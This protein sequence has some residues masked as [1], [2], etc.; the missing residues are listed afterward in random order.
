[1]SKE[2]NYLTL[3]RK[4]MVDGLIFATIGANTEHLRMLR[5]Q[6]MPVV[7]IARAPEGVEIDAV[8]VDNRRG[9]REAT[10]H[11]LRLG[12]RRIAFVGGPAAVSSATERLAGYRDALRAAGLRSDPAL[13][14]AGGFRADGGAAAVDALLRRGIS[15]T[16]IVAGN[17]LMA[18]GAMEELRRRGCRLPEDMAVV[19]FDD[20]T[21]ASLV[22]PPLTTVAQ[23]KYRMGSLAME[24]LLELIGGGDREPRRLVLNPQL[25]VR[26]SCG[27]GIEFGPDTRRASTSRIMAAEGT[28]EGGIVG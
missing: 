8:L 26:R 14:A 18:I 2:Q 28:T 10:E 12:H 15:F 1:L 27:A 22:E 16:A 4:R 11:L 7:L 24:R 5:R 23:P 13:I 3:L 9:S 20:I 21:F 19:G 17:D 6:R 25:V